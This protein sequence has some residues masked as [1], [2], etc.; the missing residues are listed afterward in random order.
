MSKNRKISKFCYVFDKSVKKSH[1]CPE[2]LSNLELID[3][4]HSCPI[5]K[6]ILFKN[7]SH[8]SQ[9]SLSMSEIRLNIGQK[10]IN[11]IFLS[12]ICQIDKKNLISVHCNKNHIFSQKI[13]SSFNDILFKK[14][15]STFWHFF[16]PRFWPHIPNSGSYE[17]KKKII[18]NSFNVHF[19]MNLLDR[20][21]L[22]KVGS[23]AS[24]KNLFCCTCGFW[25]FVLQVHWILHNESDINTSPLDL[26]IQIT[27]SIKTD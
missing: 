17:Q 20:G 16:W 26:W 11:F 10:T 13:L 1:F 15:H 5:V 25:K 12:K 23:Y 18:M 24:L 9:M 2:N 4:I 21:V 6:N 27:I 14:Y 19:I 3:K 8:N 7:P 22:L